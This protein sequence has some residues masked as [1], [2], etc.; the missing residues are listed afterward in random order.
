MKPRVIPLVWLL[1]CA[2]LISACGPFGGSDNKKIVEY[3]KAVG[4]DFER[5]KESLK[6]FDE[7]FKDD[8]DGI[9]KALELVKKSKSDFHTKLESAKRQAVPDNP[10]ELAAFHNSLI[11]Y[12]GDSIQLMNDLEQILLYSQQLFKSIGPIEKA[13]NT[14]LGK[15]PSME[16]VKA[17]MK[18]LKTSIN[19]SV[20]IVK[21]TTPP[22]YM[23]D[24]HSNYLA[25]LGK[26]A[27]ATDDFIFALQLTDPL[28]INATTYRYELLSNKLKLITD[29]MDADIGVQ[30]K[31]MTDIGKKLQ[32]SQDE[33]YRKLLLW[34]GEYKIGS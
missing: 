7:E 27:N 21:G 12:Y 24:S 31:K 11:G 23:S 4:P 5:S 30:Q 1:I 25:I 34:Q 18:G 28:R 17:M 9:T 22:Q 32:K 3:L 2:L 29:E 8:L 20:T 14:D 19:E 26:Y 15:A 13:M 33:L 16:E 6:L 10:K